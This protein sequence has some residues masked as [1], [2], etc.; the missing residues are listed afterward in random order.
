MADTTAS[1]PRPVETF[2]AYFRRDF[3]ALVALAASITGDALFAEDLAQEAMA[4][5][6]QQWSTVQRLDK[7]GAWV[8][9]VL[10]NLA[11]S[12]RRRAARE[13]KALLRLRPPLIPTF[14]SEPHSPVLELLDD[15][16]ARQRAVVSLHYID[17]RSVADVAEIVGIAPATVRT[18][19]ERARQTLR[20]RLHQSP[21][22]TTLPG[23]DR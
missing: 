17:D 15:L 21:P 1:A 16:P 7:P 13:A 14:P 8:R 6:H 19:L 5:A 4:K 23:E 18:Q 20:S 10:I 3:S 2:R 22:P 12:R 11:L 9:R